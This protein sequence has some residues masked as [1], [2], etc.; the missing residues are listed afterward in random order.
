MLSLHL[1][2]GFSSKPYSRV[3]LI[4][5]KCITTHTFTL[6]S[7]FI[8]PNTLLNVTSNKISCTSIMSIATTLILKDR[9]SAKETQYNTNADNKLNRLISVKWTR[10]TLKAVLGASPCSGGLQLPSCSWRSTE[11]LWQGSNAMFWWLR[12]VSVHTQF[13]NCWGEPPDT[14]PRAPWPET[15]AFHQSKCNLSP[16]NKT[17]MALGAEAGCRQY[18]FCQQMD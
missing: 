13:A 5:T 7:S 9:H 8:H 4:N 12:W 15:N 18:D 3:F 2:A 1:H 16:N 11:R 14:Y 17:I 6:T 10:N